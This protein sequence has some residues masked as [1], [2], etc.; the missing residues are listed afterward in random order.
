MT[1]HFETFLARHDFLSEGWS[2]SNLQNA[3]QRSF[4]PNELDQVGNRTPTLWE[5]QLK[6]KL[7]NAHRNEQGSLQDDTSAEHSTCSVVHKIVA[8]AETV[9]KIVRQFKTCFLNGEIEQFD[10]L[11]K[12]HGTNNIVMSLT[13]RELSQ[14]GLKCHWYLERSAA[15]RI[16]RIKIQSA[17]QSISFTSQIGVKPK[18]QLSKK[19]I[20]GM[21]LTVSTDIRVVMKE[22]LDLHVKKVALFVSLS[23]FSITT[24]EA[25]Q[26][27]SVSQ[28]RQ[29][30][31]VTQS[32][33]PLVQAAQP[34]LQSNGVRNGLLPA[35]LDSFVRQA[36]CHAEDIFG[37]EGSCDSGGL[38]P[39]ENFTECHRINTGIC[40]IRNR[41][42]TT[43]HSSWLPRA[44]GCDEFITPGCEWSKSGPCSDSNMLPITQAAEVRTRDPVEGAESSPD[45]G[46]GF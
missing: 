10:R 1:M 42:L 17:K 27:N 45:V 20:A 18:A 43:G 7:T 26:V 8:H 35:C 19:L 12:Q 21:T 15:T 2:E 30:R 3:S 33:R 37:D 13:E 41:G 25:Q 28:W 32:T 31:P 40:G 34:R 4:T 24:A 14:R 44:W 11:M 16:G 36:G 22:L 23:L 9:E 5:T 29:Q 38:P 6:R 39:F 46:A